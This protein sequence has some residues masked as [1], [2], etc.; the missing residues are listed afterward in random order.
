MRFRRT[1][2]DVAL[3]MRL[4]A[5]TQ[6]A[7]EVVI[8][9][10]GIADLALTISAAFATSSCVLLRACA[11]RALCLNAASARTCAQSELP[12]PI[13]AG[14]IAALVPHQLLAFRRAFSLV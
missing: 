1:R 10:R 7:P 8:A 9:A 12:S 5:A 13:R 2:M 11:A 6:H 3:A 4:E 14:E